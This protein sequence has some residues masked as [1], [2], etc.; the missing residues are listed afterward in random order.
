MFIRLNPLNIESFGPC[1]PAGR[2]NCILIGRRN[3]AGQYF[4]NLIFPTIALAESEVV[5]RAVLR[6]YCSCVDNTNQVSICVNGSCICQPV[7]ATGWYEWDVTSIVTQGFCTD[8]QFCLLSPNETEC[9][10][11]QFEACAAGYRPVLE[12]CVNEVPDSCIVDIVKE[13]TAG[14]ATQYTNW[15]DGSYLRNYYYF[16]ENQGSTQ[17]EAKIQVSPDKTMVVTDSEPATV[18]PQQTSYFIA[19]RPSRF[20]RLSF[21]NVSGNCANPMKVWF[22]GQL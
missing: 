5:E 7:C 19:L 13:Y 11:K 1:Y 14:E 21:R 15:I 2:I 22:Q 8:W 12:L 18:E 10:L 3:P 16:V 4:A 17:I 9:S 20:V 6:L